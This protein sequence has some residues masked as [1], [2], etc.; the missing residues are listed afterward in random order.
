MLDRVKMLQIFLGDIMPVI[1]KLHNTASRGFWCTVR[2]L[3]IA[4]KQYDESVTT[5]QDAVGRT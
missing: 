1:Q 4:P 2:A 5:K 3:R